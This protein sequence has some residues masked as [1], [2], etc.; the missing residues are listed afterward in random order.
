MVSNGAMLSGALDEGGFDFLW[1]HGGIPT[2]NPRFVTAAMKLSQ[3]IVRKI[4]T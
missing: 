1:I 4:Y 3:Q 2:G